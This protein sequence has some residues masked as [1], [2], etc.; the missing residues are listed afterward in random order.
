M[1]PME[2]SSQQLNGRR[3]MLAMIS[4]AFLGMGFARAWVALLFANPAIALPGP[5]AFPTP[6][7]VFDLGYVLLAI[8]MVFI[9][10]KVVPLGEHAWPA[11]TALALMVAAS[12]CYLLSV[13]PMAGAPVGALALASAVLGGAGFVLFSL[14]NA[15]AYATLSTLRMVLCLSLA[16]VLGS[17]VAFFGNGMAPLQLAVLVLLLPVI[18][19][20]C[21]RVAFTESDPALRPRLPFPKFSYP[22]KLY[23][24]LALYSFAYGLRQSQLVEGTGRGSTYA[25]MIVM[26]VVFASAL[27]FGNRIRLT[28][29]SMAPMLFMICGFLLIPAQNLLG[30]VASS[31]LISISYTLMHVFV[32]VLL[33][34]MARKS[35]VPAAALVAPLYC[36]QLLSLTGEGAAE[37]LALSGLSVV[38]QSTTTAIAVAVII[39]INTVLLLSERKWDSHWSVE[40]DEES[41]AEAS[42]EEER[43]ANRC[44]ELTA[45]YGLSAREDEILRLLARR[46]TM[47][48]IA[49][50][51][52]IAEGTMK[53]HVRHIYEKMAINSRKELYALLGID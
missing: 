22:Y 2:D 29:V 5:F 37:A 3:A 36:M 39:G 1:T 7:M 34:S 16:Y 47:A 12:A 21:I 45:L 14:L 17:L 53:A 35:G 24:L 27:F 9:A 49:A 32:L 11:W 23:L 19:V 51:L 13:F 38:V 4:F 30:D 42:R 31:F 20:A 41:L 46:K 18:A 43:L 50:D 28:K 44:S 52:Y 8:A 40:L 48:S 15:E 26:A 33:C 6:H 10:R 25:T